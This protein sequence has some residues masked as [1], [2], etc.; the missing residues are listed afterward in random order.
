METPTDGYVENDRI[1]T[2]HSLGKLIEWKHG[3]HSPERFSGETPHSLGKL[4]EWKLWIKLKLFCRV[5]S[6]PHSLGKLIEWKPR[7]RYV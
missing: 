3:S 6:A 4:I 5:N 1:E 7:I 2:P